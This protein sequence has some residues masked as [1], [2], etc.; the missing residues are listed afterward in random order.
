MSHI[1]QINKKSSY[2]IGGVDNSSSKKIKKISH[3]TTRFITN[4]VI[5]GP[6]EVEERSGAQY[7]CTAYFTNGDSED[8]SNSCEWGE[9]TPYASI[10][11]TGYLTTT[12][13]PNQDIHIV[14]LLQH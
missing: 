2:D 11:N 12:D 3:Q 4:L 6:A 5:S 14:Q 7:Q 8:V 13:V 1:R 9:N 10:D